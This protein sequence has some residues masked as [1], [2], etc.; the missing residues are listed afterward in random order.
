MFNKGVMKH[1]NGTSGSTSNLVSNVLRVS[2]LFL[3]GASLPLTFNKC[4]WLIFLVFGKSGMFNKCQ[5][6]HKN[7][8]SAHYK[9]IVNRPRK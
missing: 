7:S 4:K 8:T 6:Q 9:K 2:C 5:V 3:S 1:E